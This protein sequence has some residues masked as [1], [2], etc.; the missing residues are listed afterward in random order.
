MFLKS[1]FLL[2][3]ALNPEFILSEIQQKQN[4]DHV[5]TSGAMMLKIQL[6]HHRNKLHLIGIKY[7]V[8]K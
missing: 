3:P 7:K 8:L 6:C 4:M 2:S 1:L 5:T